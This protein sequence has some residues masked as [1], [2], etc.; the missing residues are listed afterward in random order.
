MWFL[1]G[2]I[3]TLAFAAHATHRRF[4]KPWSGRSDSS[5]GITYF[6]RLEKRGFSS[7]ILRIGVE[8]TKQV[9]F[10]LKSESWIDRCFRAIGVSK[11]YQTG[12]VGFDERIY[13]GSDNANVHSLIG[14]NSHVATALVN[15]FEYKGEHEA[16]VVEVINRGGQLWVEFK[17]PNAFEETHLREFAKSPVRFLRDVSTAISQST[18]QALYPSK[19]RFVVKAIMLLSVSTGLALNGIFQFMRNIWDKDTFVIDSGPLVFDGARIC[20]GIAIGLIIVALLILRRSSRTHIILIELSIVGLFGAFATSVAT[21]TEINETFDQ[22]DRER[23]EVKVVEKKI[24]RSG[25]RSSRRTYRVRTQDWTNER[26]TRRFQV[27]SRFFEDVEVGDTL[28]ITQRSGYLGYR[29][30]EGYEAE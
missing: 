7:R 23:F 2:L 13:I 22:S 15:L 6:G 17:L 27:S 19:D 29:W 26:S 4:Q 8:S 10:V 28:V 24:S 1:F 20:V 30:V 16:R 21:L 3:T 11:E 9:E 5:D 12:N 18:T 25:G 14:K